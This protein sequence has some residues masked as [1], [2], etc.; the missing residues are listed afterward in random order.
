MTGGI[1]LLKLLLNHAADP[2]YCNTIPV[3]LLG[4]LAELPGKDSGLPV[5][6]LFVKIVCEMLLLGNKE[7]VG[8]LLHGLWVY[9]TNGTLFW[10][11][12]AHGEWTYIT[13]LSSRTS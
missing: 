5:V 7:T 3:C 13:E 12:F 2:R 6:T 10:I 11:G 9:V 8:V 1:C 4:S